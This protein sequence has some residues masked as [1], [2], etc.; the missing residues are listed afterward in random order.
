M[1]ISYI[2]FKQRWA[3][4]FCVI[5]MFLIPMQVQA[6]PFEEVGI[7]TEISLD[8]F[9]I[10]SEKHRLSPGV[11]MMDPSEQRRKP[12]DLQVGDLVYV[13]GSVINGIR[14]IEWINY[15]DEDPNES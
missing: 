7:I 10:E 5:F 2:R 4:V 3:A 13:E 12:G 11:R 15:F 8:G 6:Q 1:N 9:F 14:Y